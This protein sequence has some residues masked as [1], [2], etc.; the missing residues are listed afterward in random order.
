MNISSLKRGA[1]PQRARKS[2]GRDFKAVSEESENRE[3]ESQ[4]LF[5]DLSENI[6]SP[7]RSSSAI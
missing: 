3:R 6:S 7:E 2:I 1:I 4:S 5:P